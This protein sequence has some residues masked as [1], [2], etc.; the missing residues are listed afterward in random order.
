MYKK[1]GMTLAALMVAGS[2]LAAC[3]NS[4]NGNAVN[5][6]NNGSG[7]ENTATNTAGNTGG[8]TTA[9]SGDQ[10]FRMN[11][12]SEPPTLDPSLM[13][14]NVSGTIADGIFEGLTKTDKTG[15][16]V[17]G[18]A[19]SWTVSEDSKT[20]TFK[21]RKDS[22]WSTGNPVTAHDFEYS[23]KRTLDPKAATPAPYAYQLH[24][25]EGAKEYNT[26][27]G[28]I[29][30]VGVKA[31]D[32]Y[33]LEVK[34]K[35][36]T[37]YFLSLVNFY[38][39]YPVDK[40]AV[41][42]DPKWA[43]E[44]A[45]FSS[46][47]PFKLS[48]WQHSASVEIVKN[49][50]YYGT[51]DVKLDKV[52]FEM[53]GDSNTELSS[54]T[55]GALDWAGKPT[56]TIP[57]PQVDK[58]R[59]DK[60]P[61]LQIEN[62]ASTYFYIFNQSKKPFNNVKVR[63]ALS[64]SIDR[65]LL[66]DK[67]VLG[68]QTPAFGF[69]PPTIKGQEKSFREETQQTYFEENVEEAKKLLAEGLKEEGMS[70]F[71]ATTLIYNT[72]D[73]HAKIATAVTE[74][75]KTNLGIDV[76]TE[77]QEWKVFLQNRTSLNYDI[78]RAGWGADYNDAMTFL[79]LYITGSGNND[80]G[81]KNPAYDKLIEDAYVTADQAE[82]SKLLAQAEKMLMDESVVMPVY[83]DTAASLVK[84]YVKDTFITYNGNINYN[85]AYIAK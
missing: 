35:N 28:S 63:K 67:V 49:E 26:G 33:T 24:Y 7:G 40:V 13:Q 82:R 9:P 25:I 76:K 17:P 54:Y 81:Y 43:A 10:V 4:N 74:M 69:V 78:S 12:T 42:K 22:K 30:K 72:S 62:T 79:D 2:V 66:V 85:Y 64:I 51:A 61:E 77:V 19:E 6:S 31:L 52:K 73:S 68:G 11:I 55:T 83:Y 60:N 8:E 5:S 75:W 29:D 41:E 56:G 70:A 3:G 39:Y 34:L 53:M 23:W 57:A 18:M 71:P 47:G 44:A 16:T 65:K 15:E 27:K 21:I 37:S 1:T 38:T 58:F 48:A 80:L 20:Y 36:P 84:P 45:S 32:D 59:K 50:N 14:D 46:N